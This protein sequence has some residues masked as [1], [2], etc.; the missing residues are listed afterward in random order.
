[1]SNLLEAFG[2][3]DAPGNIVI[4][5]KK[6]G[7]GSKIQAFAGALSA[8]EYA[9]AKANEYDVYFGMCPQS[10]LAVGSRGTTE[11]AQALLAVWADVDVAGGEH[12]NANLPTK[13]QAADAIK[14]L[15]L[16]PSAVVWSGGGYHVY[17]F[18][19]KPLVID[20]EES[21]ERAKALSAGW[22][23]FVRTRMSPFDLDSTADLARVL[24]VPN[25]M[26]HKSDPPKPVEV[27]SL[28]AKRRYTVEEISGYLKKKG[29]N[30]AA[31][32]KNY[33]RDVFENRNQFLISYAG[34]LKNQMTKEAVKTAV[35]KKNAE[36]CKP[37]LPE[38]EIQNTIFKT[39]NRWD[40]VVI[41]DDQGE[42]FEDS[43]KGNARA[44]V[45]YFGENL[46]YVA[47]QKKWYV[48]NGRAWEPNDV[49]AERA[50]KK[51]G[52]MWSEKAGQAETEASK[53]ELR[54]RAFKASSARA[55]KAMVELA[56]SEVAV[57]AKSDQFDR[58]PWKL[59]CANGVVNLKTGKLLPHNRE[60]MHTKM[61]PV[62]YNPDAPCPRW[63]AFLDRIMDNKQHLVSFLQK[64]AGYS[65]TGDTSEQVLF[66]LYGSGANGKSTFITALQ[67]MM[68][69]YA[70]GITQDVLIRKNTESS[71]TND[72]ARLK[73]ARFVSSSEIDEGKQ[74]AEA[75]VKA[76]LGGE[77][78]TARFL[79]QEFFDFQPEFKIWFSANH[80]PQVRSGGEGFWRR[81]MLIPFAVFIPKPERDPELEAKLLAESSGI[82]A[83]AVRGCLAWQRE[84]L[85]APEEVRSAVEEYREDEDILAPFLNDRCKLHPLGETSRRE[86][87]KAY[88]GWCE[89]NFERPLSKKVFAA[90]IGEKGVTSRKSNGD[91]LWIGIAVRGVGTPGMPIDEDKW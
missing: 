80:K 20:G 32:L 63:T 13:E 55:I 34:T 3:D 16:K 28:D 2:F 69:G 48:F 58:D 12:K 43:D 15:P 24:R 25:T 9:L 85:E 45:N 41:A 90:R 29:T 27:V 5:S 67:K 19:D 18:L 71:N 59:N 78:M 36:R 77:L 11:N 47:D 66:F 56:R 21:R 44:L 37:P 83:W 22:Q 60:D 73:G 57:Y 4:F 72:I 33:D 1:M 46:R 70:K 84:G 74:M 68:N 40:D 26:N 61:V 75:K 23:E 35:L 86:L 79:H 8:T 10:D 87:Y 50:A 31:G 52:D 88:A 76:M 89:E 54:K 7:G 42:A 51:I 91:R 65:L 30:L 39:I 49:A 17:W 81:V 62:E 82:L 53:T 64:A 14:A 6:K 38:F